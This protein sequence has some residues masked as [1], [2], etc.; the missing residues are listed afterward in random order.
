M[1]KF[2]SNKFISIREIM[3][4]LGS[5]VT[6]KLTQIHAGTG[7]DTTSF[8]RVVWVIKVLKKCLT[9]NEKLRFLNTISV[10]CKVSDTTAKDVEK[11]IQT[12]S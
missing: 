2:E 5:G 7:G 11:F 10:S 12:L 6:T 9:G 1:M 8:L 4:Y 3:E